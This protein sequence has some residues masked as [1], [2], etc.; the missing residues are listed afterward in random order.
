MSR[1]RAFDKSVASR[2]WCGNAQGAGGSLKLG[3]FGI[4]RVVFG[5]DA[6]AV[7]VEGDRTALEADVLFQ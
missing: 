3:G 7:A 2:V 1:R 6:V 4:F 5:K